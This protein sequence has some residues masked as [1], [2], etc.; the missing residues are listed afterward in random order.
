MLDIGNTFPLKRNDQTIKEKDYEE[1]FILK[2]EMN[3]EVCMDF[4]FILKCVYLF[5][6]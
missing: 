4:V 6:L 1:Y 3:F 5:W 2:K